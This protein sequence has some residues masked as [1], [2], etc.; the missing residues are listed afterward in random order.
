MFKVQSPTRVFAL[1]LNFA[2][3]AWVGLFKC[4]ANIF[5]CSKVQSHHFSGAV[6]QAW[7]Q[8]AVD[9]VVK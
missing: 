3:L 4:N 1:A 7:M 5:Q 8:R 6:L 9:F 2:T